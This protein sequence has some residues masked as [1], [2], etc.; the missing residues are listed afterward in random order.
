MKRFCKA[1]HPLALV[2]TTL[3]CLACSPDDPRTFAGFTYG[4]G[5]N[6]FA[7]E[8][9][10]LRTESETTILEAGR[11]DDPVYL[12]LSWPRGAASKSPV[13]LGAAEVQ[14]K[15]KGAS[16]TLSQGHIVVQSEIGDIRHGSFELESKTEDGRTLK[17]VGSFTARVNPP[18]TP[19]P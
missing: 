6:T 3:L 15:D 16:A 18:A 9:A 13:P 14:V 4:G 1:I 19:S 5:G 7:A 10:E 17:T 11:P 8:P 12:K 2:L